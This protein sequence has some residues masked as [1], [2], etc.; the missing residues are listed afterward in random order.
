MRAYA[1][2]AAPDGEWHAD[3]DEPLSDR[4]GIV[5]SLR[6]YGL[7]VVVGTLLGGI[8]GFGLARQMPPQYQ[9]EA[10]LVLSDPGGPAFLG[11]VTQASTDRT[12]SLAKQ[13]NIMTSSIVLDRV[14]QRLGDGHSVRELRSRLVVRPSAD[15]AAVSIVAK[16]PDGQ[17]A[18]ALAN[19]VAVA[20]QDVV[21]QR[22]SQAAAKAIS[23]LAQTRASLQAELDAG[24]E[25]TGGQ[26]TPR[27][28]QLSEQ[29]VD[30]DRREED[31]REKLA[32]YG[33][34][35]ELFERADQPVAPTQ[36]KPR[37]GALLGAL[38][39]LLGTGLWAWWAAAR[40]PRTE[41][42]DD[43]ARVLG[44][45]L[46]GEVPAPRA[47]LRLAGGSRSPTVLTPVVADGHHLVVASLQHQLA[48]IGGSSVAVT[49]VGLDDSRTATTLSIA[50]AA[51]EEQS[52][53]LLIDAD[54][55]T[56]RLSEVDGVHRVDAERDL[57]VARLPPGKR[58]SATE[59]VG[60]L[61]DIG[62]AMV[63]PI[64]RNGS[65]PQYPAS[66]RAPDVRQ[67][68][69]AVGPLFDL[70]LIDT[71]PVLAAS[72]A[73]RVAGQAD[74]VVLLVA[75]R[76]LLRDLRA[77]REHLAFSTTP[78]IGYVY[79]RPPS[80]ALGRWTRGRTRPDRPGQGGTVTPVAAAG[81]VGGDVP[82]EEP[83]VS[84]GPRSGA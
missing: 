77:V 50:T 65:D 83:P 56:R 82:A 68:L 75:H 70:V 73:L 17:S 33:S 46:L 11:S 5:A 62:S 72:D 61:V 8:A 21:A 55:Q 44:V 22:A 13:A 31:I 74:A 1:G 51:S 59:Y 30:L 80:G 10:S 16:G 23:A 48:G 29:I 38:V 67:A 41:G 14:V 79:V 2:G 69:S 28:Q 27:Q 84:S 40:N 78:L 36:P 9:A 6:R 24:P 52:R 81:S 20:Y 57:H 18:A 63:L 66:Y 26:L 76:L 34:G 49:S 35:V 58:R 42:S 15:L 19:D 7:V 45:P 37:L 4:P 53:V 39:G 64:T 32:L 3:A 12:A 54:K 71:P 25:S 60:R 47:S 43:P